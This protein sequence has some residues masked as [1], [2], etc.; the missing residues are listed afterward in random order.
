MSAFPGIC[1]YHVS[2]LL[3]VSASGLRAE[4]DAVFFLSPA[5]DRQNRIHRNRKDDR[6]SDQIVH[7]GQTYAVLPLINR[8]RRRKAEQVLK[9]L[10]RKS[11]LFPEHTDV[12]PG[13]LH[14]H[15]RDVHGNTAFHCIKKTA[16]SAENERMHSS[17]QRNPYL[18][19]GFS[20]YLPV[21]RCTSNNTFQDFS[22]R[23]V[24]WACIRTVNRFIFGTPFFQLI[25]CHG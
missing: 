16:R 4:S 17:L 5:F 12:L 24:F 25:S 13:S 2:C 21:F 15:N 9:F 3:Y 22:C 20:G 11:L 7:A 18:S 6:Q 1:Q 14:I 10:Y 19:P 23:R 8:L